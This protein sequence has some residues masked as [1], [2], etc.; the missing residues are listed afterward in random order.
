[1]ALNQA[2]ARLGPAA[3]QVSWLEADVREA[4]LPRPSFNVWH[5]RA[6]FH[7]LTDADDRRRYVEQVRLAVRPGGHV[8]IAT[9]AHDGPIRCSGLEVV[10]YT[11]ETLHS[12]FGESFSLLSSTR[13]EHTTPFGTQQAFVYCVFRYQPTAEGASE[14]SSDS[15]L[16]RP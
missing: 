14:V 15:E 5:D 11:P 3:V 12:E 9:F 1:M 13:E 2:Q 6:V 4:H 10:C 16:D 7:F 8:L